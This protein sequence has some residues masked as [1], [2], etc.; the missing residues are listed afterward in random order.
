VKPGAK[1]FAKQ[2]QCHPSYSYLE[3]AIFHLKRHFKGHD[4]FVENE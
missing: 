4:A 1:R 2:I 3:I